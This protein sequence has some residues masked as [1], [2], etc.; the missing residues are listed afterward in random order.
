MRGAPAPRLLRAPGTAPPTV[1][2]RRAQRS[3]LW[4]DMLYESAGRPIVVDQLVKDLPRGRI[5]VLSKT[6]EVLYDSYSIQNKE[7]L[8][9]V[10]DL[11]NALPPRQTGP[12]FGT[13]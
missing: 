9:Y 2:S 13:T 10:K 5:K 12:S 6:G 7:K 3:A 8:E 4:Q 11:M 1:A